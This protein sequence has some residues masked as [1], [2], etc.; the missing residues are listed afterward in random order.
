MQSYPNYCY[1][2]ILYYMYL[3]LNKQ[4]NSLFVKKC[5]KGHS[6]WYTYPRLARIILILNKLK[7]Q[8]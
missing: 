8:K 4:K 3:I 1:K 5:K 7:I 2:Q 6:S